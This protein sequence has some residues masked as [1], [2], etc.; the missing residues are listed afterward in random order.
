MSEKLPTEHEVRSNVDAYALAPWGENLDYD[1][2]RK[3]L[4]HIHEHE[5][6]FVKTYRQNPNELPYLYVHGFNYKNDIDALIGDEF[7]GSGAYYTAQDP[8]IIASALAECGNVSY[9]SS[10]HAAKDVQIPDEMKPR[11][12]VFPELIESIFAENQSD[13][14]V[15]YTHRD[16]AVFKAVSS[17]D[18]NSFKVKI[19]SY[20]M[21][22][23]LSAKYNNNHTIDRLELVVIKRAS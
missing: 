12:Q 2:T 15:F 21:G 4:E 23:K 5:G 1:E 22:A 10:I 19:V 9:I 7:S 16:T 13:S 8:S 18:A 11:L 3:Y 6:G 14:I 20:E 17:L